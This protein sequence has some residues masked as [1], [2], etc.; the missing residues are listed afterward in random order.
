MRRTAILVILVT[1]LAACSQ[2][3][4]LPT[5]SPTATPRPP[6]RTLAPTLTRAPTEPPA[7]TLTP[8]IIPPVAIHPLALNETN[9]GLGMQR[10]AVFG[11]GEPND[12]TWS[13][14]GSIF[15]VATARGV[16]LYD[17]STLEETGF[18][19]VNDSVSALAFSPQSGLLVSVG[20]D[21][22]TRLW[23]IYTGNQLRQ[24]NFCCYADFTP[25][26][27]YLVTAGAG[28]IRVWGLPSP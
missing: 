13:P 24:L 21:G 28:V 9:A 25:D 5:V 15:A 14:D 19:D 3:S 10:L 7:A 27:R 17:G 20:Y 18:I 16:W 2:S 8:P 6:T 23:D 22:T 11:T 4:G 12:M 1:L 26:G